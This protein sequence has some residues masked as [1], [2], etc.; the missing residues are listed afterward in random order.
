MEEMDGGLEGQNKASP[1]LNGRFLNDRHEW[2][3]RHFTP[4]ISASHMAFNVTSEPHPRRRAPPCR[5]AKLFV[6]S[7]NVQRGAAVDGFWHRPA[8]C[9]PVWSSVCVFVRVCLHTGHMHVNTFPPVTFT[10][11]WHLNH[12]WCLSNMSWSFMKTFYRM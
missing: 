2:R 11:F 6:F 8:Q 5:S 3:R 1:C 4:V 10:A 9:I 12:E 7:V